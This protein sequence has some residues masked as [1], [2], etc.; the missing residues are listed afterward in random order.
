MLTWT[1]QVFTL[2]HEDA[3]VVKKGLDHLS[4]VWS[5]WQAA[6]AASYAND[7]V[8]RPHPFEVNVLLDCG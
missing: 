6:E 1:A 2:V 3:T 5:A 7:D 4:Q 8:S